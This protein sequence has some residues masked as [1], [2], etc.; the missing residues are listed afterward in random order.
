M[1]LA[2]RRLV[3]DSALPLQLYPA[4]WTGPLVGVQREAGR[5]LPLP[6]SLLLRGHGVELLLSRRLLWFSSCS[7]SRTFAFLRF[8]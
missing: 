6:S 1:L 2:V 3:H 7:A 8:I 4:V 5:F